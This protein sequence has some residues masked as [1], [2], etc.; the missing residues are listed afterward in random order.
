MSHKKSWFKNMDKT[1]KTKVK[2]ANGSLMEVEG[3]GDVMMHT[4]KE[5]DDDKPQGDDDDQIQEHDDDVDDGL[6]QSIG[7]NLDVS[8]VSNAGAPPVQE[9]KIEV[10]LEPIDAKK[11]KKKKEKEKEKKTTV[12]LVDEMKIEASDTKK[13]EAKA[14]F[15]MR[16]G[17]FPASTSKVECCN[18]SRDGR[19]L[20]TF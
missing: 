1:Y 14:S 4:I 18:F 6:Q 2:I 7:A 20:V 19:L 5:N 3:K 13:N 17:I 8:D 12:V 16:F 9:E 10:Q 15:S 11:K